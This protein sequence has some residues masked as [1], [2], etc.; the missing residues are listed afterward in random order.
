LAVLRERLSSLA[1][2]KVLL[3]ALLSPLPYCFKRLEDGAHARVEDGR[4]LGMALPMCIKSWASIS[5]KLG[6]KDGFKCNI[7]IIN[8]LA[9]LLIGTF[10]GN[11]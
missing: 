4:S 2:F 9:S 6:L 5:S 7:L 11:D 8:D 10:S 1:V 3:G